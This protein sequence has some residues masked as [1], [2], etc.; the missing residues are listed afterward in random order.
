MPRLVAGQDVDRRGVGSRAVSRAVSTDASDGYGALSRGVGDL[1]EVALRFRAEDEETEA[2]E[3]EIWAAEQFADRL[4]N[5]E[6]GYLNTRQRAA[7]D[8]F[9]AL[10]GEL[11]EIRTQALG[12]VSSD[13]AREA[14]D[15]SLRSRIVSARSR[16]G[17]HMAGQRREHYVSVGEASIARMRA[18]LAL[19]PLDP[20][21]IGAAFTGVRAEVRAIGRQAGWDQEQIDARVHEEMEEIASDTIL[22]LINT[23]PDAAAVL[24]AVHQEHLSPQMRTRVEGMLHTRQEDAA[25]QGHVG[26]ILGREPTAAPRPTMGPL[27]GATGARRE[28]GSLQIPG[29]LITRRHAPDGVYGRTATANAQPFAGI[30]VHHTASEDA[31]A[32]VRYGH[33]D[34]PDRGGRF[35]YHYYI[36]PNGDVIEGAPLTARTNHVKP[37]GAL[38]NSN[39]I[40]ISFVGAAQTKTRPDG[41][42]IAVGSEPTPA[43]L[44]QARLL[45]AGLADEFDISPDQVFGHGEVQSDR[46]ASEGG[47]FAQSIRAGALEAEPEALAPQPTLA[48]YASQLAEAH[49]IA[50]GDVRDRVI[51][52]I[53]QH[54]TDEMRRRADEDR[55]LRTDIYGR[56]EAG[57]STS[58]MTAEERAEMRPVSSID[59]LTAE[60]RVTLGTAGL[61]DVAAYLAMRRGDS[62]VTSETEDV[63]RWLDLYEMA[64][65]TDEGVRRRFALEYDLR[66]DAGRLTEARIRELAKLQG[67]IRDD[68]QPTPER[69]LPAFPA[70]GA[71]MNQAVMMELGR[72][73][74]ARPSP[75]ELDTA[76]GKRDA[77]VFGN[78]QAFLI[79]EVRRFRQAEGRNPEPGEIIGMARKATAEVQTRDAGWFSSARERPLMQVRFDELPYVLEA[80]GVTD[81]AGQPITVDLLRSRLE[82]AGRSARDQDVLLLAQTLISRRLTTDAGGDAAGF[83][84][85]R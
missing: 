55:A 76:S 33:R 62:E 15:L 46:H 27:R 50:D 49:S 21:Q 85:A 60:E 83:G 54:Y 29:V 48:S 20:D 47:A 56:I 59:D 36:A 70:M 18:D 75:S 57:I 52:Q 35:G 28:G 9:G 39:A 13:R 16:A 53:R 64:T 24:Y 3:A 31:D 12:R 17:T 37:G 22:P 23:A 4:H 67:D 32:M 71:I 14:L 26:R 40:G 2:K 82:A 68:L 11:E 80:Q 77:A 45:V 19:N 25:V 41:S 38:S 44:A 78:A 79:E 10:D 5:P 84:S 58:T 8:S 42:V 34:D 74:I 61:R 66:N 73:G 63:G 1:A 81:G 30:I 7:I 69:N 43:Q 72:F 65:S 6:T 51:T